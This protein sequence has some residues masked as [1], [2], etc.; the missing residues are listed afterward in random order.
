M[1]EYIYI[2]VVV[3]ITIS[4]N[5]SIAYGENDIAYMLVGDLCSF[6]TDVKSSQSSYWKQSILYCKRHYNNHSVVI[7]AFFYSYK[8]YPIYFTIYS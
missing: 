3:A 4:L 5:I 1:K 7:M 8:Q 6:I 2:V